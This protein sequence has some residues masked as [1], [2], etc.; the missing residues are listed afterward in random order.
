MTKTAAQKIEEIFQ[1]VRSN[2]KYLERDYKTIGGMW[3]VDTW[4]LEDTNLPLRVQMM[5]EGYTSCV[6]LFPEL[7]AMVTYNQE[8]KFY[9][10]DEA[11]LNELHD[12][13]FG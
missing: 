6:M 1:H 10:G 9:Q 7:H 13:I 4:Y 8:P 11:A 3:T 5:D 2:G 12:R